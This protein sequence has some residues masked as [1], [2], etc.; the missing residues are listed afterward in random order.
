M[1]IDLPVPSLCLTVSAKGLNCDRPKVPSLS[2]D[3]AY[4]LLSHISNQIPCLAFIPSAPKI[5]NRPYAHPMA[6]LCH[7]HTYDF[8]LPPTIGYQILTM[9]TS[10]LFK[11]SLKFLDWPPNL[12][13]PK[14]LP[15]HVSIQTSSLFM[16]PQKYPPSSL[17][18][19]NDSI[20][21]KSFPCSQ[22]NTLLSSSLHCLYPPK[23]PPCF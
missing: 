14:S 5:P 12:V 8:W 7:I 4:S 15:C 2:Y 3:Y 21:P 22:W 16:Y 1:T 18:P 19:S 6:L 23:L 17:P 20:H 9:E 10:S 11:C 13:K